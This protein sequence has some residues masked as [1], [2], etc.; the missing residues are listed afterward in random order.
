MNG[1]GC[2]DCP[3]E[4]CAT[5]VY[6]GR[7]CAE[8]RNNIG[9]PL[10]K[11]NMEHIRCSNEKRL[12]KAIVCF[13]QAIQSGY[14]PSLD[15]NEWEAFLRGQYKENQWLPEKKPERTWRTLLADIVAAARTALSQLWN[16]D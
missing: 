10:P 9:L 7:V 16:F 2:R 12:A 13:A 11:T 1:P 4:Y 3:V 6:R 15:E 5:S 8:L 14:S